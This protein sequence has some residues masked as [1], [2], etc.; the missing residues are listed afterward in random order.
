MKCDRILFGCVLASACLLCGG[1][2][3]QVVTEFSSGMSAG[4]VPNGIAA[5]PDGN[6]WFADNGANKIGKITTAGVITEYGSCWTR[7][8]R[9]S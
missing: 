6:L 7:N 8:S 1:A 9:N 3:A 4:A 2:W 5:G